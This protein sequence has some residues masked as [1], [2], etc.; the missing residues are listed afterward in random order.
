MWI[1]YIL[2]MFRGHFGRHFQGIFVIIILFMANW[3][4]LMST[5]ESAYY[6]FKPFIET[7]P[8]F[9]PIQGL[10]IKFKNTPQFLLL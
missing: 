3:V 10:T 7:F 5:V 9:F 4:H 1:V 8:P 2:F 6:L